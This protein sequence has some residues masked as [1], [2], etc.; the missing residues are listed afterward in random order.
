MLLCSAGHVHDSF[1]HPLCYR[2]QLSYALPQ[3]IYPASSHVPAF[4]MDPHHRR[5]RALDTAATVNN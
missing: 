2:Q 3:R 4:E 1:Q 5:T